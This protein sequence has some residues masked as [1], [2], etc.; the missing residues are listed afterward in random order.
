ML[1][2]RQ[3]LQLSA[4]ATA[5]AFCASLPRFAHAQE[6]LESRVIF[7]ESLSWV[8]EHSAHNMCQRM[9][10]AGFNV[11]MPCVWHG[12][13]TSWPSS[14]APWDNYKLDEMARWNSSFDPLGKLVE[15]AAQYQ[16]EVHPWFN[17]TLRQREFLPHFYG[18]GTPA[19]AFDVHRPDFRT[20][21]SNLMIECVSRYPVHGINLDY[22]RSVSIC[23]SPE[24][25]RQYHHHTNRNLMLD[26]LSYG[27]SADAREAI[28]DW[29]EQAV[30]E[31]VRRVSS[32]VRKNQPNLLISLCGHPGHPNL[33]I[34]GQKSI[35]WAD[36]GLID[37]VYDMR[38][39][40]EPNWE[41]MRAVQKSMKRPEAYAVLVGNYDLV[42]AHQI[43]VSSAGS[44]VAAQI[45]RSRQVAPGNGVGVYL[46]SLLNDEQ[47]NALRSG[48]FHTPAT[49]KWARATAVDLSTPTGL[50]VQ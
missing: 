18:P 22:I 3:F 9:K 14:L 25:A 4:A 19:E 26:R 31:I 15:I 47:I 21:I 46:Y 35:K 20:F 23:Q 34:Q 42:G 16:I 2:R 36:E 33:Y 24:C 13:G 1:S 17:V 8:T 10:Q 28:A 11:V 12:R 5:S 49:P 39:P 48:P 38:Y 32:H 44:R 29:N 41:E 6:V 30:G 37:V 43:S 7:D 27:A 50:L 40:A 45:V